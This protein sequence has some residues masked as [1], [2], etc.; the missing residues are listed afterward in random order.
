MTISNSI[1]LKSGWNWVSF[2]RHADDMKINSYLGHV[3]RGNWTSGDVIKSQGGEGFSTFG[4]EGWNT[5]TGIEKLNTKTMYKI[6]VQTD[7]TLKIVGRLSFRDEV[8]QE[9]KG[10]ESWNWV[11]YPHVEN[12]FVNDVFN[13]SGDDDYLKSETEFSLHSNGS[14]LPYGDLITMERTRGYLM[15]IKKENVKLEYLDLF[16]KRIDGSVQ[17]SYIKQ[18]TVK[19]TPINDQLNENKTITTTSDEF[20]NFS[21]LLSEFDLNEIYLFQGSGGINLFT[22]KSSETDFTS[23]RKVTKEGNLILSPLST[24]ANATIIEKAYN[25]ERITNEILDDESTKAF[26]KL[27]LNEVLL[28]TDYIKSKSF[29]IAS[30]S[31][32]VGSLLK[33]MSGVGKRVS[34]ETRYSS[35]TTI[36]AASIIN[37]ISTLSQV[38]ELIPTIVTTF[39]EEANIE[40]PEVTISKVTNI[41]SKI[42]GII[43]T[44]DTSTSETNVEFAKISFVT[45]DLSNL[46]A[47]GTT[48][49]IERIDTATFDNKVKE[50]EESVTVIQQPDLIR[51]TIE[52]IQFFLNSVEEYDFVMNEFTIRITF[53]EKVKGIN[54]NNIS[55]TNCTLLS[56]Y[57]YE[58]YSTDFTFTAVVNNLGKISMTIDENAVYDKGNNFLLEQISINTNIETRGEVLLPIITNIDFYKEEILQTVFVTGTF[59]IKIVFT[60]PVKG[61]SLNNVFFSNCQLTSFNPKNSLEEYSYDWYITANVVSDGDIFMDILSQGIQDRSNN[62]V[63]KQDNIDVHMKATILN[64]NLYSIENQTINSID[65]VI[66]VNKIILNSSVNGQIKAGQVNLKGIIINKVEPTTF[67][68][69]RQ[70]AFK[71]V[72][73]GNNVYEAINDPSYVFWNRMTESV[74]FNSSSLYFID[75]E[76]DGFPIESNLTKIKFRVEFDTNSAQNPSIASG[77][78]LDS[79]INNNGSG[80]L[81]TEYEEQTEGAY[82]IKLNMSGSYS[83]EDENIINNAANVW[84]NIITS[85]I[86]PEANEDMIINVN[87]K[88]M[89]SNILGSAG[90]TY[91]TITSTNKYIPIEGDMTF[92]TINWEMQKSD[93]KVNGR[94]EAFYTV[95][96]EMGHVLGIGTLWD[97]NNL[98]ST[99]RLWYT[100][101]NALREYRNCNQ[102]QQLVALPIEDDG[103][104]GTAYGHPEEGDSVHNYRYNDGKLHPG[105]DTELMT[106]YSEGLTN[107]DPLSKITIGFLE[108]I[109]FDVDYNCSDDFKIT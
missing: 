90:P 21:F 68:A 71:N 66:D 94:N 78:L 81:Y 27:G 59:S 22:N 37:S 44:I 8:S 58:D 91:Y 60:V 97:F 11:S 105:L 76:G 100:G 34:D 41:A 40:I 87:F 74:I 54:L 25:G 26:Q 2:N 80:H 79:S 49:E 96:H 51:P 42:Q 98:V 103:G 3:E 48:D 102:N 93:I 61:L 38:N 95:L 30:K 83:M 62:Y 13:N 77:L 84:S 35:I 56:M 89:A 43:Q 19:A 70:Q 28:N 82:K 55:F 39:I 92:N 106:G 73:S 109:G 67:L 72:Y 64:S 4:N 65:L 32:T 14:W 15:R 16:E 12:R 99:D 9:L 52:N 63:S 29:D 69:N 57:E 5:L 10:N 23:V 104:G 46:I 86:L 1:Y 101:H 88:K 36:A 6:Y 7:V 20:G 47:S 24:V 107:P 17:S 53:N 108:D 50:A 18:S 85:R 33:I 75:L 31:A 45:S